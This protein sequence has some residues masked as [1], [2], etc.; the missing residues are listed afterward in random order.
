MK[1]LKN[2]LNQYKLYCAFFLTIGFAPVAMSQSGIVV[3]GHNCISSSSEWPATADAVDTDDVGAVSSSSNIRRVWHKNYLDTLFYAFTRESD[4]GAGFALHFDTDCDASTGDVAK[5][6][7]ELALFFYINS[8]S[9]NGKQA[10]RWTSASGGSYVP[11]TNTFVTGLGDSTCGRSDYNFIELK[12]AMNQL[13]NVCGVGSCGGVQLSHITSYSGTS[14][15]SSIKDKISLEIFNFVNDAPIADAS[16]SSKVCSGDTIVFDASSS[17][18]NN[19]GYNALDSMKS[20]EWDMDYTGVFTVDKTGPVVEESYFQLVGSQTHNVALIVTDAFNCKDTIE[21]IYVTAYASPTVM[22]GSIIDS[23][24]MNQCANFTWNYNVLS[25]L[26]FNGDTL[27]QFNWTFPDGGTATGKSASK[28]YSQ[29]FWT[30]PGDLNT[31]LVGTDT[32]GCTATHTITKPLPVDLIYF[33]AEALANTVL[34]EWQTAS[35]L[36][37]DYFVIEK[38][39]NG[40]DFEELAVVSAHGNSNQLIS[41]SYTD[42]ELSGSHMYYRLRQFD[43][44]GAS[45]LFKT[46]VVE[47]QE[48]TMFTATPN[49]ANDVITIHLPE[50]IRSANLSIINAQGQLIDS[51]IAED[52]FKINTQELK[53]G[54]YYVQLSTDRIV[55]NRLIRIVH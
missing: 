23:A 18:F 27:S 26:D 9:I 10:Y 54:I 40:K 53:A 12:V 21:N 34:I 35:E 6:G 7:A 20:Y 36:N 4:G 37:A 44:N 15:S 25:S 19:S 29:C 48:N 22:G 41:Y 39:L 14:F 33:N 42:T 32:N 5:G 8:N 13:V 38:S 1:T 3:D 51:Y 24:G 50:N 28:V 16:Y 52:N 55:Q 11:T 17:S 49:P 30:L 31:Y 2:T 47:L 43:Y 45:E 46:V